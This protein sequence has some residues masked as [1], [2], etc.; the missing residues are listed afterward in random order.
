MRQWSGKRGAALQGALG[1]T[2]LILVLLSALALGGNRPVAWTLLAMALLPLFA[3]QIALD[4]ARGL[5]DPARRAWGPALLFLPVLAWAI[6]QTLPMGASAWAHPA[7]ALVPEAPGRISATPIRG[8]H[9]VVRLAAYGMVFWT[10]LRAACDPARAWGFL[11]L[12]A[13]WSAALALYGLA[14]AALGVNPILGES[15]SPVV[16]AS[17][18][19]RNSY[20]TYAVFGLI[21]NLAVFLRVQ[22]TSGRAGG[23]RHRRAREA[24]ERFL[25]GG[26]LYGAGVLLCLAALLA[27]QSRAGALAGLAAILTF[28]AVQRG[29]AAGSRKFAWLAVAVVFGFALV[30]L[31]G[32]LAAR[33]MASG[34]ESPRFAIY[35]RIVE[36]I[37][38]RPLLGHGL[39]AFRDVFRAHVPP[40]AAQADWELAHNSYLE[41]ALEL[42]L[43]A[44]G[45][46][47]LAL[48]ILTGVILRGALVRR[49]NRSFARV[50]LACLAAAGFHALFDFSLQMPAVAALFAAILGLGWAQSW[51][52]GRR[53]EPD[54]AR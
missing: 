12:I 20:A 47:Y 16:S 29:P 8:Q 34:A 26:W 3:A 48:L 49:R 22:E 11:R 53:R 7:W 13:L 1:W 21:A 46:F 23:A 10:L 31:S 18:V 28:A 35:P 52:E 54:A 2:C 27:T 32:G 39:G 4:Q 44:A 43:P 40:E 45:L 50:A 42:G 38:E 15:A 5:P 25:G 41:N 6:F 14:T 33:L 36:A 51:P 30:A 24:I 17:F 37:R 9:H 19:N